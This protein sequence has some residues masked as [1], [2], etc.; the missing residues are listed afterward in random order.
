MC[1]L[2][3]GAQIALDVAVG[4]C[5]LHNR[6]ITHFDIKSANVLLSTQFRAKLADLG[7]AK[8]LEEGQTH[9]SKEETW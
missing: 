1:T 6:F 8:I 5:Y 2:C 7:L 4:I 9:F 3:R